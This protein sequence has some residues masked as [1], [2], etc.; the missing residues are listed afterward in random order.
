MTKWTC[1]H[2]LP[3]T[4]P[5]HQ[6]QISEL[7]AEQTQ[8]E[9]LGLRRHTYGGRLFLTISEGNGRKESKLHSNKFFNRVTL[10]N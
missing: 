5:W 8:W 3:D 7:P 9:D 1:Q 10:S 4:P 6:I 2:S